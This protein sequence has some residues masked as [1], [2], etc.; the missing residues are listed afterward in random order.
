MNQDFQNPQIIHF[1]TET[2]GVEG[3]K[4]KWKDLENKIKE[5]YPTIK[6]VYSRSDPSSGQMAVSTHRQDKDAIEKWVADTIEVDGKT[7]KFKKL[8][9]DPLKDFW[10]KEGKHY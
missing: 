7:F 1:E 2:Q 5:K 6:I 8:D 4:I 9:G 10:Q 3:E